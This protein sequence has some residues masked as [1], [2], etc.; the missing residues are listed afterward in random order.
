MLLIDDM[1]EGD[2]K[3]L[4]VDDSIPVTYIGYTV[5]LLNSLSAALLEKFFATTANLPYNDISAKNADSLMV[6]I[7]GCDLIQQKQRS[8]DNHSS[9]V[10]DIL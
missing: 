9:A 7:D 8:S 1:E 5:R 3:H 2:F 10:Y 4:N 6:L